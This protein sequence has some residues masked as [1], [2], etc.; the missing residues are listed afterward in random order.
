MQQPN[1]TY[2]NGVQRMPLSLEYGTADVTVDAERV[3]GSPDGIDIAFPL[4]YHQDR[5]CT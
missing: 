1:P 3:I 2:V 5:S 4:Y